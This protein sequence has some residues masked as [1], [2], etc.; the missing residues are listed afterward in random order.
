MLAKAETLTFSLPTDPRSLSAE[1]LVYLGV[2]AFP[3]RV[4]WRMD[5]FAA[6]SASFNQPRINSRRMAAID[7]AAKAI[8]TRMQAVELIRPV[9]A[10]RNPLVT[11]TLSDPDG[12][13]SPTITAMASRHP[14]M[15]KPNV[16]ARIWRPSAPV[17]HMALALANRHLDNWSIVRLVRDGSWLPRTARSAVMFGMQIE[18]RYPEAGPLVP[19][20]IKP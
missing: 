17:I 9:L 16:L 6:V 19:L 15:D 5:L 4:Q 7:R 1:A 14:T 18:A 13:F 11:L 8:N 10:A 20:S 2:L 12:R 3:G